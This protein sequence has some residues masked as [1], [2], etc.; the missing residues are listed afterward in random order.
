MAMISINRDVWSSLLG[1][2]LVRSVRGDVQRSEIG[3]A[4][5]PTGRRQRRRRRGRRIVAE[6]GRHFSRTV[7]D[8]HRAT[9]EV[10]AAASQLPRLLNSELALAF[11]AYS[12]AI[13]SL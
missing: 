5:A 4:K 2:P 3:Q 11:C 12:A 6:R 13:A 1:Q 9:A 8:T 10:A 7:K